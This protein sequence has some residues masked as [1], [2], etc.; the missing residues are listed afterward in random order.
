MSI[1]A[2][3]RVD[4]ADYVGAVLLVYT[5]LIFVNV[6]LSWIG[7]FRPIPYNLTLRAVTG[8]VEET[9]DPFLNV[10]RSFLPR[11]GPFDISP[12]VA[13]LVL[14]IGGA[15]IVGLIRG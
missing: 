9:T 15:L 8:F 2:L 12:I 6:L 14:S 3:S 5:V 1:L 13:I 7:Q 4:V 11:L 10:F